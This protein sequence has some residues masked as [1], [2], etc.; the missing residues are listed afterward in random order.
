MSGVFQRISSIWREFCKR[1]AYGA[2]IHPDGI[3]AQAE[4]LA[5]LA[6]LALRSTAAL[7]ALECR[8]LAQLAQSMRQ[9]RETAHS[10]E[11]CRLSADRRLALH[12]QLLTA[13]EKLLASLQ[14]TQISTEKLQ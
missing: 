10:P 9:L 12:R 5:R 11:F 6:N 8:H 14:K 4:E 2:L 3:A 7:S 1:R 13:R